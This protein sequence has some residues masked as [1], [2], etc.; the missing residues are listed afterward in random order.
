[1]AIINKGKIV[2]NLRF[3]SVEKTVA[4]RRLK[5]RADGDQKHFGHNLKFSESLVFGNE[6][7]FAANGKA[8]KHYRIWGEKVCILK[9][10]I[11]GDHRNI[12]I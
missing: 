11:L 1:M 2:K 12:L 5:L 6:A 8:N 3:K 7:T 10:N 9:L 4:H